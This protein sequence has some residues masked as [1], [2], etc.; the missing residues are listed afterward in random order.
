M[1]TKLIII[2]IKDCAF[3]IVEDVKIASE[4]SETTI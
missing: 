4:F 2:L 1:N 3:N